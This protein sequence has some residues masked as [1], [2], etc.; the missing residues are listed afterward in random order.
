M[1]DPVALPPPGTLLGEQSGHALD[2]APGD[3][4]NRAIAPPAARPPLPRTDPPDRGWSLGLL[5]V[6]HVATVVRR[7][8][9]ARALR[10]LWRPSERGRSPRSPARA[11]TARR[12][13]GRRPSA[14]RRGTP[15]RPGAG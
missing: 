5:F 7:I 3:V 13:S 8:T 9:R 15:S 12:R 6:T 14:R 11:R 4:R 10:C 2:D 1:Q